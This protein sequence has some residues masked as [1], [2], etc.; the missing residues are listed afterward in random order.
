[1]NHL[2]EC[3]AGIISMR[4]LLLAVFTLLGG[5]G[6]LGYVSAQ[7]QA[8]SLCEALV[9]H[10][11]ECLRPCEWVVSGYDTGYIEI[12]G[13]PSSETYFVPFSTPQCMPMEEQQFACI[14]DKDSMAHF[15]VAAGIIE[16]HGA[17]A[18]PPR[19]RVPKIEPEM[20]TVP[21]QW[22]VGGYGE[23]PRFE[24]S[25]T[26]PAQCIPK[27]DLFSRREPPSCLR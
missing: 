20:S 12:E 24:P 6:G 27:A 25:N 7:A 19:R 16:V 26:I 10:K 23:G 5:L 15:V 13:E 14:I 1:M 2:A 17:P 3:F 9:V 18:P 4:N 8:R 11:I 21:C 22:V